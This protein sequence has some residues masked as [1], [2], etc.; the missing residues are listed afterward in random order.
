MLRYACALTFLGVGLASHSMADEL[1]TSQPRAA[2]KFVS[3]QRATQ[4]MRPDV[5]G[6]DA[7]LPVSPAAQTFQAAPTPDD[8]EAPVTRE[9]PRPE[10][11]PTLFVFRTQFRGDGYPYGAS[12][13]GLDD[14]Y[15]V[16]VPGVNV[17]VPLQ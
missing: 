7:V 5:Y 11:G 10:G 13:Q 9:K 16:K 8:A 12:P 15:A 3:H 14:K 1:V 2:V 17:T 6:G 4:T